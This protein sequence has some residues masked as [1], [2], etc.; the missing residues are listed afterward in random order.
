V[1]III[2]I[3]IN[4]L[5]CSDFKDIFNWKNFKEVLKDDIDVVESL[6]RQF[7]KVKGATK[8]PV[9]WSKVQ[10]LVL[11]KLISFFFFFF[12]TKYVVMRF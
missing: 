12:P 11:F 6:P 9:S 5:N 1:K 10:K 4:F 8:A 7:A 3:L 2:I